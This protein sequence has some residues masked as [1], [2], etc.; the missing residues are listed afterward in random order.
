MT[1]RSIQVPCFH[2]AITPSGTAT[3]TDSTR[4]DSAIE[5]DGSTRPA[6]ICVTGT[7]EISDTPRSPCSSRPIQVM[8]C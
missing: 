7:L 6:I 2:A 3:R 1:K 8:N 5:I 4:V